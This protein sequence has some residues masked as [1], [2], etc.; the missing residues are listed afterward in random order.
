M[1][2]DRGDSHFED[3][4]SLEKACRHIALFLWW[5]VERGLGGEVHKDLKL[6]RK[7]PTKYFIG[8]CDCKLW[9]E[10]FNAEGFKFAEAKYDDYCGESERYAKKLKLDDYEVK[11]NA[12][13]AEHFFAYLDGLLASWREKTAKPKVA[14]K[15]KTTKKAKKPKKKR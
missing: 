7:A 4:G 6:I 8:A 5:A 14:A 3:A 13:T 12:A 9:E 10:D 2:I 15:S 1:S 11:E